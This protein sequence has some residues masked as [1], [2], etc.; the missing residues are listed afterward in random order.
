[1]QDDGNLVLYGPH[2]A[3]WSSA[4]PGTDALNAPG[5]LLAGQFLH[6]ANGRFRLAQ[7]GDGNL[8][9]YGDGRPIWATGTDGSPGATLALQT[10]GNLVLYDINNQPIW[11][12]RTAG[13]R[14]NHLTVQDDGNLVLYRPQHAVWGSGT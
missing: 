11:Y 12:S 5:R 3:L 9:L 2:G 8:V 10:D 6:S 1:M 14:A 7:Q 4:T 13:T